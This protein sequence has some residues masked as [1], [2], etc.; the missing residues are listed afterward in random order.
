MIANAGVRIY[1]GLF[2]AE[3]IK[4]LKLATL[5]FMQYKWGIMP[6]WQKRC[7]IILMCW[8]NISCAKLFTGDQPCRCWTETQLFRDLLRLHHQG[9]CG[10]W[11][12]VADIYN[13]SMRLPVS[14]LCSRRAESNCA[15]T[16][17]TLNLLPCCFTWCPSCRTILFSFWHT[18]HCAFLG[19]SSCIYVRV[20]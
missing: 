10:Q 1:R 9:R 6:S 11:P 19:F 16:H 3:T 17:P 15:V 13:S 4:Y 7:F 12:Y 18:F 20:P 8:L 2:K 14:V 5:I